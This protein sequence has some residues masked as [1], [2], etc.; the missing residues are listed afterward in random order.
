MGSLARFVNQVVPDESIS[1]APSAWVPP[2]EAANSSLYLELLVADPLPLQRCPT[3][4]TF[5]VSPEAI[6]AGVAARAY[7]SK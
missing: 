5:I 7:I 1:V 2:D 4:T 3:C 6:A